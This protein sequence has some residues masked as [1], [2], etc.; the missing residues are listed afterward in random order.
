MKDRMA[1]SSRHTVRVQKGAIGVAKDRNGEASSRT[2]GLARRAK[3]LEQEPRQ[4]AP[5]PNPE[6]RDGHEGHQSQ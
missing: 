4:I 3:G 1:A 5:T 2:P 6:P